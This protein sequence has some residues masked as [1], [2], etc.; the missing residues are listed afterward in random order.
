[1]RIVV[2]GAMVPKQNLQ[3]FEGHTGVSI[4]SPVNGMPYQIK[5]MVL[6]FKGMTAH[7]TYQLREEAILIDTQIKNY[8]SA[9]LVQTPSTELNVIPE[10]YPLVSPFFARIVDA[11]DTQEIIDT[12]LDRVLSDMDVMALVKPYE[13]L[14][15]LDPVS[16]PEIFDVDY[17]RLVPHMYDTPVT[18]STPK[19]RFLLQVVRLFGKGRISLANFITV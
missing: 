15:P 1:L 14:L 6:P 8:L 5:D 17:T 10:L 13:P 4:A 3:F 16:L 9:K 7:K 12:Q 11:L 18:L 2:N 19:Y